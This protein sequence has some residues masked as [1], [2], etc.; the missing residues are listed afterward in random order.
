MPEC[1]SFVDPLY[2]FTPGNLLRALETRMIKIGKSYIPVNTT[3]LTDHDITQQQP[4]TQPVRT[5][6]VNNPPGTEPAITFM[7]QQLGRQP[8]RA[9]NIT[10]R[11]ATCES[12]N[13]QTGT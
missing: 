3:D 10:T 2:G 13:M 5:K 8:M 9:K 12:K 4:G 6:I 7:W 1:A 11:K